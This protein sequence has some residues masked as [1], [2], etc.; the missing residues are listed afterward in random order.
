MIFAV[1]LRPVYTGDFCR[2]NSMQF[3]SQ[4]NRIRFQTCSKPLRYRGDKSHLVYT[5]DFEAVTLARQK[6]HRVAATKIACVSGPFNKVSLHKVI[7]TCTRSTAS[8][9]KTYNNK[10]DH[11]QPKLTTHAFA[12]ANSDHFLCLLQAE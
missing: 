1:M 5:C 10:N 7:I 9:N 3:L 11:L 4:Q 6:L 12:C 2:S 8:Q